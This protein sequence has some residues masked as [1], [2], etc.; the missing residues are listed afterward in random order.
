MDV[1]VADEASNS[2]MRQCSDSDMAEITI[3]EDVKGRS[4]TVL[5]MAVNH[6][7]STTVDD[8]HEQVVSDM[9]LSPFKRRILSRSGVTAES[10]HQGSLRSRLGL[11]SFASSHGI[12]K[13]GR[14]GSARH[15]PSAHLGD[16]DNTGPFSLIV[17][18]PKDIFIFLISY[19]IDFN[20]LL[21][22]RSTCRV[23]CNTMPLELL[24]R[25][26]TDIVLSLRAEEKLELS[27]YRAAHRRQPHSNL[28]GLFYSTYAWQLQERPATHLTCYGCLELKPLHEF[29]ERMSS[30]GTGLGGRC[31]ELRRC[32]ACMCRYLSIGGVWW[33][34]HW[35]RKSDMVRRR[36]RVERWAR[37][38]T[39]GERLVKVPKDDERGVCRVCG[40]F[41]EELYWGC[42]GCF[43]K[44][45]RRRRNRFWEGIGLRFAVYNDDDDGNNEDELTRTDLAVKWL[46]E[47]TE[48]WGSSRARKRRVK[49]ARR[50]ENG[51]W[52]FRIIRGSVS[53]EGSWEGR[54]EALVEHLNGRGINADLDEQEQNDKRS[55]HEQLGHPPTQAGT[56]KA[57]DE[58]PLMMNRREQRCTACWEPCLFRDP[59]YVLGMAYAKP[60]SFDRW[61]Q[62]CQQEQR[63]KAAKRQR[64]IANNNSGIDTTEEIVESMSMLFT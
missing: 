55:A 57:L 13:H 41:G 35:V 25:I 19:H 15:N 31:A 56:W 32:K 3:C 16:V 42:V 23:I 38:V 34:E 40:I 2:M 58:L 22:L 33:R 43:E 7:Q 39:R 18:L 45:E 24:A 20:S 12:P 4:L 27:A 59:V 6:E 60:L 47:M 26:R 37:W 50:R 29:V 61:C 9:S 64:N 14:N 30:R 1:T 10:T 8:G 52:W 36:G 11:I 54:V 49:C 63:G 44:E 62:D 48:E 5:P 28:L 21:A 53:W 17:S 46:I 51:S